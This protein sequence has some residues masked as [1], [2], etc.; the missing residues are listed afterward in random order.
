MEIETTVQVDSGASNLKA[1]GGPGN[2]ATVLGMID[3]LGEQFMYRV[4]FSSEDLAKATFAV[5][6]GTV[7]ETL[8]AADLFARRGG[9]PHF[10]TWRTR[11]NTV[12]TPR[13]RLLTTLARTV[14]PVPDLLTMLED[15]SDQMLSESEVNTSRQA[16][17]GS[18]HEFFQVAIEPY[19][20]R[21]HS[22][23]RAD[24]AARGR[25]VLAGG[26]EQVLGTLHPSIRWSAP[27]LEIPG[28]NDED[29]MLDGRG[30]VLVPSLFVSTKPGILIDG[31]SDRP[32]MLIFPVPIDSAVATAIWEL[33]ER[34]AARAL[35]ALVGRTRALI[36]HNLIDGCTTGEL[37]RRVGI[38][39]AAASQHTAVLRKAGLIT[40]MRELNTALHSLTPLG[41]ALL[42]GHDFQEITVA[43]MQQFDA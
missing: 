1:N 35:S 15:H 36:I 5:S 39:A 20:P 14:R 42:K 30:I 25:I 9:G 12:L 19:W 34:N 7:G 41:I 21:I 13:A 26:I 29:I 22:R 8:F 38:T 28:S 33:S 43:R 10:T 16:L 17:L 24:C 2:R 31:N 32:P 4:Y 3:I 40:T 6:L 37:G 11:A 23:L 18:I 27:V